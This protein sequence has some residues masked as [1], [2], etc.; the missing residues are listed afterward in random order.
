MSVSVPANSIY[1]EDDNLDFTGRW[2]QSV[3]VS[4][5]PRISLVIGATVVQANFVSSPTANTTLFR[6]TVVPGLADN[7]GITVGA[8]TLNGGSIRSGAGINATTTLNAVSSTAGRVLVRTGIPSAP[9]IGTA[10]AGEASATVSFAAPASSGSS[11]IITYT[12]QSFPGG[13]T[14]T[15]S[16]QSDHGQPASPMARL[17][18]SR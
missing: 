15:G 8:L 5:T 11:P 6:Y 10:T 16:G 1:R 13:L 12:V 2:D 17:T 4:G 9:I 18:A 3:T 7:N 14:G